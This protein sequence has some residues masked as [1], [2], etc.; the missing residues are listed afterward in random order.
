M[1]RSAARLTVIPGTTLFSSEVWTRVSVRLSLSGRELEIVRL[2]FEERTETE[3]AAACGISKHTVHTHLERLYH[4]LGVRSRVG[5]VLRIVT[6]FLTLDPQSL[7]R[8]MSRVDE[9][10]TAP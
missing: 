1:R 5:L 3:I 6:E 10:S 2:V 8:A 9:C 7:P 4:K